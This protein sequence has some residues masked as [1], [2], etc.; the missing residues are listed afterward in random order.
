MGLKLNSI[1]VSVP[2]EGG[3]VEVDEWPGVRLRVRSINSKDYLVA[4]SVLV[5]DA[6]K[7][8]KREGGREP[9]AEDLEPGLGKLAAVHLLRGWEGIVDDEGAA[10][11]FTQEKA[12][13]L[14]TDARYKALEDQV[15][16]AAGKVGQVDAQFVEDA[17][18]N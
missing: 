9:I 13:E 1:A 17:V 7:L 10:V 18:K 15:F 2:L 16:H 4:R 12:I 14:L 6:M 11:P 3:W 5:K 8:L